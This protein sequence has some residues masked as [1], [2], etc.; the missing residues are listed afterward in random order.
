VW[1]FVDEAK[2]RC[3]DGFEYET[4]VEQCTTDPCTPGIPR[5]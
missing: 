2:W 5:D 3:P 1:C 4:R